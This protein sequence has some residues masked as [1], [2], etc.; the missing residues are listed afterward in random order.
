MGCCCQAR[1]KEKCVVARLGTQ[2]GVW[3]GPGNI[4]ARLWTQCGVST[5]LPG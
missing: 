4:V 5:L 1:D 3:A 2:S